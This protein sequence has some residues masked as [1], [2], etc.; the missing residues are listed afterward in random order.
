MGAPSS[1]RPDA[2]RVFGSL[3]LA[4]TRTVLARIAVVLVSKISL[5]VPQRAGGKRDPIS[6]CSSPV[7]RL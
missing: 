6:A 1:S 3:A 2:G 4:G 7:M 5:L